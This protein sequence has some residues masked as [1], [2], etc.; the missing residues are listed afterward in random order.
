MYVSKGIASFDVVELNDGTSSVPFSYRVVAKRRGFE[1]RR[2]DYTAAGENDP[3]LYP[4]SA[5]D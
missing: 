1:H 2:L 3:Y 4:E 5:N